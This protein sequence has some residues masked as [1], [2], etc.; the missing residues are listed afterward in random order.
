MKSVPAGVTE[1]LAQLGEVWNEGLT[2]FGG[3]FLAG[4]DF[5]NADAFFCPVAY[6]VQTYGLNVDATSAAYLQQLL[7][8]PAMQESYKA[9]L[10]E[11]MR[12]ERYED[13]ARSAGRVTEDFEQGRKVGRNSD[14]S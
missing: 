12:I 11:T 6:R 14:R 9:G 8:L 1:D 10:A 13:H 5:S 7:K 4:K 3:P 2:T